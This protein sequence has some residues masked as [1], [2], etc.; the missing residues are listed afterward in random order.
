MMPLRID[1]VAVL[2]TE[3]DAFTTSSLLPPDFARL[4]GDGDNVR[5]VGDGD[6]GRLPADDSVVPNS[7]LTLRRS[8]S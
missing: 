5:L 4:A 1:G 2:D 7:S 3:V 6:G 8:C